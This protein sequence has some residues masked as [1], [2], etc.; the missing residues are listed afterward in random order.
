MR[1]AAGLRAMGTWLRRRCGLL[2]MYI[3]SRF[4]FVPRAPF[5]TLFGAAVYI[6]TF[7]TKVL[8]GAVLFGLLVAKL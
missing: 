2:A 6:R 7:N 4:C 8:L 5:T 1:V 3:R